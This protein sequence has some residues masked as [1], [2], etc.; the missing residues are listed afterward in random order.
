MIRRPPRSTLFPYT[1]LFRSRGRVLGEQVR[2]HRPLR[3]A[4][5]RARAARHPRDDGPSGAGA[6]G[7]VH[8]RGDGPHAAR[9]GADV[10]GAAGVLA[11]GAACARARP[12]RGDGAGVYRD[13]VPGA[14]AAARALSSHDGANAAARAA[15]PRELNF[16][17][18][19]ALATPA[20]SGTRAP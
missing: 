8:A 15:G 14:G 13:R 12:V 7:D 16:G 19:T 10:P 2:R 1:T 6:D 9:R 3:G 17:A 5:L 4:L 11:P 18:T 20:A